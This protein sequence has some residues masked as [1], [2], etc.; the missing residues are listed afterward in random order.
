M[1]IFLPASV[2]SSF[3]R[4]ISCFFIIPSVFYHLNCSISALAF[5]Y[6]YLLSIGTFGVYI[7]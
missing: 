5:I 1:V 2:S 4:I 7:P 6:F 3:F